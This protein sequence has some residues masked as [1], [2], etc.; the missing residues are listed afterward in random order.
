MSVKAPTSAGHHHFGGPRR[1]SGQ[2]VPPPSAS[3]SKQTSV[4]TTPEHD[5]PTAAGGREAREV[6]APPTPSKSPLGLPHEADQ[7]GAA[8]VGA[9]AKV[10]R[11]RAASQA[12][13][14]P[15]PR[16]RSGTPR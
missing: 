7:I 3:V 1:L 8:E 4:A 10:A 12:T 11:C 15:R 6:Q 2:R 9:E 5:D 16:E 14:L 13:A